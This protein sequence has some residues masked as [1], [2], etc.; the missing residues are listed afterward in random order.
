MRV[1]KICQIIA[2]SGSGGLERHVIDLTN[3]L[4]LEHELT[5]I[6]PEQMRAELS[7]EVNFIAMDFSRSRYNL[8]LYRDLLRALQS[9]S[10]DIIHAQANKA[11]VLLSQLRRFL[12]PKL[13]GTLHN[14]R[15]NKGRAF[16]KVD[17]V[18]AVSQEAASRV[19][20]AKDVSVIYNGIELN[21]DHAT[22]SKKEL[23]EAFNLSPDRPLL[24]SVGR[25]VSAKGY[26]LLIQAMQG[27]DANLLIVGDGELKAA[28]QQQIDQLGI[29]RQVILTGHRTD[30][31]RVLKAVDGMVISSRNEGFSYVFVEALLSKIPVISTD[32]SA[33]EFLPGHLI[34]QKESGAIKQMLQDHV[35][36]PEA[37]RKHMEPVFHR[38][39]EELTLN[40]MVN[41]TLDVYQRVLLN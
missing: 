1:M 18:I 8:F 11:T 5:L 6:A 30:V 23:A 35:F 14:S 4:A 17:H 32:V 31:M 27:V 38:A 25:L 37:W 22:I 13:I 7:S 20:S 41:R 3:Q 15:K 16:N 36:T 19:S 40:R 9:E 26:D 29:S 34:M 24:C 10:F 39:D 28:L 21:K 2:S 12:K 33:K